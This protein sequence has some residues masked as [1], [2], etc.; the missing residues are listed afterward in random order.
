MLCTLPS[1][2]HTKP[3]FRGAYHSRRVQEAYRKKGRF[4]NRFWR[5]ANKNM[6]IKP[7][8]LFKGR[9]VLHKKLVYNFLST[10]LYIIFF[11]W[12]VPRMIAP[13]G[14]PLFLPFICKIAHWW[15]WTQNCNPAFYAK[16][17]SLKEEGSF[18][19]RKTLFFYS[20]K[21]LYLLLNIAWNSSINWIFR[22]ISR[23]EWPRWPRP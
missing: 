11:S 7:P 2:K 3:D 15:S 10:S 16:R 19:A 20:L 12:P 1:I 23:K 21:F 8:F 18:N 13:A 5:E 6:L 17:S 9:T 22:A 4:S 14:G